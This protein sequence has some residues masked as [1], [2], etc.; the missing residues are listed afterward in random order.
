MSVLEVVKPNVRRPRENER[1][2]E[3]QSGDHTSD[4]ARAEAGSSH[5]APPSG[6][7]EARGQVDVLFQ[8][9]VGC[10]SL[11]PSNVALSHPRNL[12]LAEVLK[13][14]SVRHND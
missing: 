11:G 2:M 9:L 7:A 10:G 5:A 14:I 4:S 12:W 3:S 13:S 1:G 6:D 8:A